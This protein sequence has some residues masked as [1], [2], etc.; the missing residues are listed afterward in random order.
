VAWSDAH[1]ES[2]SLKSPPV[3]MVPTSS[4]AASRSRSR[5]RHSNSTRF[6]VQ[7]VGGGIVGLI[8]AQLILFWIPFSLDRAQRDP[9]GLA[10]TLAS[11]PVISSL[12]PPSLSE[13]LAVSGDLTTAA[14]GDP[15]PASQGEAASVGAS[16]PPTEEVVAASVPSRLPDAGATQASEATAA[17]APDTAVRAHVEPRDGATVPVADSGANSKP[18]VASSNPGKHS[19][20]AQIAI[21]VQDGAAEPKPPTTPAPPAE[22]RSPAPATRVA[23]VVDA[24]RIGDRMAQLESAELAWDSRPPDATREERERLF[25]EFYDALA[26]LGDAFARIDPAD[27]RRDSHASELWYR[28]KVLEKQPDKVMLIGRVSGIWL[29]REREHNGIALCGKVL[30]HQRV[31][32]V[33]ETR[34]MLESRDERQVIILGRPELGPFQPGSRLLLLGAIAADSRQPSGAQEGTLDVAIVPGFCLT[35]AASAP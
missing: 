25:L 23:D 2:F 11:I 20:D 14:Q 10:T 3:N 32:R 29:D 12:V 6:A 5:R 22:T 31:N 35:L 26:R 19:P 8:I 7:V 21:H 16:S 13:S 9:L 24:Q 34:V 28:M 30:S 18:D 15:A 33:T 27:P 4:Y 17:P 1:G